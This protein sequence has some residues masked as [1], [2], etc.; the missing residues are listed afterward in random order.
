MGPWGR[1][2]LELVGLAMIGDGLMGA[3]HPRR[4]AAFWHFGPRAWR[5]MDEALIARPDL[6]RVLGLT[7]AGLGFWLASRQLPD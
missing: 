6:V 3:L 1:R 5:A 7:E 4:Y 2:V